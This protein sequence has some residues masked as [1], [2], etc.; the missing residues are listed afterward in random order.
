MIIDR[1]SHIACVCDLCE[2]GENFESL[3]AIRE[4]GWT[5]HWNPNLSLTWAQVPK[6]LCPTCSTE[7]RQSELWLQEQSHAELKVP[8]TI[9]ENTNDNAIYGPRNWNE[10]PYEFIDG[11]LVGY[12]ISTVPGYVNTFY[13]AHAS[14]HQ[15]RCRSDDR[16]DLDRI[17]KAVGC[18]VAVH[19]QVLYRDGDSPVFM[20]AD[21]LTVFERGSLMD[22]QPL[23]PIVEPK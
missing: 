19:G 5:A 6:Q 22:R 2:K 10:T 11:R 7:E 23:I 4:S 9:D 15:I 12:N 3:K 21:N 13:L 14:G 8:V 1:L 16:I 20:L 17:K 18:P